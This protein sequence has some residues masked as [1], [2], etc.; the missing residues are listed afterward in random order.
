MD[1]VPWLDL[2]DGLDEIIRSETIYVDRKEVQQKE[3]KIIDVVARLVLLHPREQ[4]HDDLS[5]IRLQCGSDTEHLATAVVVTA[6]KHIQRHM[7]HDALQKLEAP[8]IVYLAR[9][10]PLLHNT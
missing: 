1:T 2:V 7:Q 4:R 5:E 8:S 9:H 6:R 10:E 3:R